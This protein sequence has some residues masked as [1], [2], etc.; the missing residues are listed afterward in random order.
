MMARL[1][2]FAAFFT[3]FLLLSALSV[4]A[5][6]GYGTSS[7]TVSPNPASVVAGKSAVVNYTVGLASGN[8]WGT[9]FAVV[10][11]TRL[12]AQGMSVAITNPSGDP[13][14]SGTLT[15]I[16]AYNTSPREYDLVLRATGDDPSVNDTVLVVD[17]LS[18]CLRRPPS[19]RARTATSAA[20]RRTA[21]PHRE[22]FTTAPTCP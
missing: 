21:A 14:F 19:C 13:P 12:A 18:S 17:V 16:T 10:N 2:N 22:R 7:I 20:T 1:S 5:Q 3:A 9:A 4:S 8:T 15:I 11:Q 6:N